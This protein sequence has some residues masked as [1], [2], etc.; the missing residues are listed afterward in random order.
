MGRLDARAFEWEVTEFDFKGVNQVVYQ[1]NGVTIRSIPAIHSLDGSVS[2]ILEWNGLKLA[3]SSDTSPNKWW[4]EY[5]KGADLAIHEC[6]SP[7]EVLIQKQNYEPTFALWLST[8]GHTSPAQFGKV[9]AET[10]PRMAIG[11]HFYN[12]HDTLPII[13]EG[14]RSTYDG[15]LALATD[16]MV[17]NV[18][19]D[20]IRVRMAAIDDEKRSAKERAESARRLIEF[21]AGEQQPIAEV[22]D[23]VW[24]GAETRL[25]VSSDLSHYLSY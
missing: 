6:F 4:T 17:F 25:V 23:R 16:Y 22:L 20:D 1:E 2:Y 7:A 21:R 12:D 15:P 14:V 3:Y 18:T 10:K 9:M 8:M 13:L 5:A 24:G 11:Y 19:K